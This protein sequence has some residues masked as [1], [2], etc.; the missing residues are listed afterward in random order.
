MRMLTR[1]FGRKCLIWPRKV[2]RWCTEMEDMKALF[3]I[4][5]VIMFHILKPPH[6]FKTET[7]Y[8]ILTHIT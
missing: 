5:A 3:D 8:P 4:L 6:P 2:R 7:M 1:G